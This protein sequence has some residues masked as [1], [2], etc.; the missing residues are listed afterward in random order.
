[1]NRRSGRR[2]GIPPGLLYLIGVSNLMVLAPAIDAQESI[3][4]PCLDVPAD[5]QALKP[6]PTD[7]PIPAN[8]NYFRGTRFSMGATGPVNRRQTV[9]LHRLGELRRTIRALQS[10]T[11]A[12]DEAPSGVAPPADAAAPASEGPANAPPASNHGPAEEGSR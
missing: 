8:R 6:L 3:C 2:F 4:D 1:M 10:L 7:W 11:P 12:G 9:D 5:Y